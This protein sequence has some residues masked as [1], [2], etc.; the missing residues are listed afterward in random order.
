MEAPTTLRLERRVG[1]R[2]LAA[3]RQNLPGDEAVPSQLK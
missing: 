1:G 2:H 3:A